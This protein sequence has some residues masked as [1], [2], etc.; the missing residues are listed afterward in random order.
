M[1]RFV[2]LVIPLVAAATVF[3][4]SID[5]GRADK[6]NTYGVWVINVNRSSCDLACRADG[7]NG[8]FIAGQYKDSGGNYSICRWSTITADDYL[9]FGRPGF[10]HQEGSPDVCKVQ[11]KGSTTR[12]DCLCK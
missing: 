8:A 3:A 5:L 12:F 2:G 1:R 11:G 10:Q 6:P 4:L 9:E 7:H